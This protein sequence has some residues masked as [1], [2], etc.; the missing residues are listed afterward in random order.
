MQGRAPVT[1]VAVSA[2][3][4]FDIVV[5]AGGRAPG[6]NPLCDNEP[7]PMLCICN[8]PMIWYCL[9]PWIAAGCGTFFLCV[10]EDYAALQSYLCR[11]FPSVEFV[12]VLIPLTQNETPSTTCDV[13]KAYLKHKESL[14]LDRLNQPRDALLLSC[15]TFLPGVDVGHFIQ[16]FYVSVASVSVLLFR[17]LAAPTG[18]GGGPSGPSAKGNTAQTSGKGGKGS[19]SGGGAAAK[20]YKYSFSCVAYE[21]GDDGPCS[22]DGVSGAHGAMWGEGDSGGIFHHRLHF[23]CPREDEPDP[24]VSFG[25]SSRRPNLTFAADTVDVH[26]YLVRNWVLH[27]VAESAGEGMTVQRDCIPFLVRS[28]HST[29]NTVQN[30]FLHPGTKIKHNIPDHWFL[31]EDSPVAPFNARRVSLLPTAADKLFVACTIYE[32]QENKC[33]RAYRVKTREDFIAVNNDILVN[34]C[35]MLGLM[36]AQVNPEGTLRPTSEARN[37][38]TSRGA[39]ERRDA[40]LPLVATSA[41]ALCRLLPDSPFTVVLKSGSQQVHVKCSFLRSVL[42]DSAY[43]TSSIVGS[44]VTL[45][46]NV[47]ITNSIILDNVEIGSNAIIINCV[48]GSSAMVAAGVRLMQCTVGPQCVVESDKRDAVLR[49]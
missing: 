32:E 10:N 16:N 11:A 23:I 28:Q 15:D 46:A 27:Y 20:P 13:V 29:V 1:R 4:L 35:K 12:F 48:I 25:F 14:K 2:S 22:I 36:D 9:S 44:N 33:M 3:T 19:H 26:C 7:K 41:M 42:S 8:R 30:V 5:F 39:D 24:S 18:K 34:K 45:G 6:L 21:E 47:R 43:I 31:R 38:L 49:T 37:K 17:P 40:P